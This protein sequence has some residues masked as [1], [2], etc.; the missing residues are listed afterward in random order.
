MPVDSDFMIYCL[1]IVYIL[2]NLS[3]K[4]VDSNFACADE[5]VPF[6]ARYTK[7]FCQIYVDSHVF[8]KPRLRSLLHKHT[9]TDMLDL[10]GYNVNIR[11]HQDIIC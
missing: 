8:L 2:P 10:R 6:A 11:Y 1:V 4:P 7:A 3:E 5:F 9:N